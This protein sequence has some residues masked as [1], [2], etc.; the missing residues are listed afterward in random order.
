[1]HAKS[2]ANRAQLQS[3]GACALVMRRASKLGITVGITVTE[4]R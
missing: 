2:D 3:E 4:L 1:M